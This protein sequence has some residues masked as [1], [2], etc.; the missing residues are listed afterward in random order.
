MGSVVFGFHK[1]EVGAMKWVLFVVGLILGAGGA[2]A[3]VVYSQMHKPAETDD[4]ILF[5]DKTFSD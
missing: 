3:T 4:N 2:F 1:E 5:S